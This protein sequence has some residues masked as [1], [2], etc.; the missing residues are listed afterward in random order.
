[1]AP[2]E[3]CRLVLAGKPP[4]GC[5]SQRTLVCQGGEQG[6]LLHCQQWRGANDSA[7]GQGWRVTASFDPSGVVT[8]QNSA[9]VLGS[10]GAGAG[11]GAGGVAGACVRVLEGHAGERVT[12]LVALGDGRL[13]SASSSTE[14]V[15]CVWE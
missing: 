3:F 7:E 12:A 1:M 2:E 4:G 5:L 9:V 6:G 10:R 11:G 13:A 8:M 15:I 14:G